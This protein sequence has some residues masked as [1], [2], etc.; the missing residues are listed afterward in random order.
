MKNNKKIY[1]VS[2]AHLGF[3]NY[4][5][6]LKREKL[7]VEWL[8]KIKLDAEEIYLMGDLFDF[9]FEYKKVVPRGFTR[10]LGKIAEITDSGIPVHFFTGNHDIWIFDYLP[11]EI[12]IILHKEPIVKIF[13]D[14]IFYLAH[15]D[16]LGP[17]DK[18]FKFLKKIF[19][20]PFYQWFFTRLHPNFGVGSA[21]YWSLKSRYAK[22]KRPGEYDFKGVED[23]WLVQYSR[24]LLEEKHFDFLIYGH[25]HVPLDF[26]ISKTSRH[27][28]LGDWLAN[29]TYGVFDGT[30]FELLNYKE[31]D[32]SDIYGN[33]EK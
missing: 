26:K 31:P 21:Q 19:T 32:W 18:G 17:H 11:K 14:K 29:F 12:G 6:S 3:P 24:K 15:G 4:E 2:D 8:D 27:I 1:F 5:Q 20:S 25:R 7:L 23:E 22:A 13:N 28:N 16:G 30:N 10:F 33:K 9:W